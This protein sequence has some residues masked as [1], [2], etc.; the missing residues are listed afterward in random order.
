MT[1]GIVNLLNCN[2]GNGAGNNKTERQAMASDYLKQLRKRAGATQETLSKVLGIART[3]YIAMESGQTEPNRAEIMKLSQF[4]QLAPGDIIEERLPSEEPIDIQISAKAAELLY[5]ESHAADTETQSREVDPTVNP[6][7]LRNVLLYLLDKIGAKP[8]VG[9]TVI[10]KLLYFID[11]DYYE[12]NGRSI[13]GLS[14]IKNHYGPT[15]ARGFSDLVK[16]MEQNGEM[17]IVETSY[18]SHTQRKYLPVT[19]YDLSVLSGDEIE[20]INS[21]IA[22]LGGKTAAELSDFSHKDIPWAVTEPK[23][24]I[25][26]QYA[27]YRTDLTS[28]REFEDDL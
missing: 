5:R 1:Y 6:A 20:H 9:E 15:P 16:A 14:Y 18:F 28:V 4:Y 17:E 12:K 10:Y 8:N 24:V 13:T 25:D 11:F 21:E 3:T 26:Y 19:T 27:M 22:R 23:Q 2:K 7:K